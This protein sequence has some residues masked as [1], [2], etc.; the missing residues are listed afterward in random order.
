MGL[1]LRAERMKKLVR[2]DFSYSDK[3]YSE[4]PKTMDQFMDTGFLL[5]EVEGHEVYIE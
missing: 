5:D 2:K 1:L 4:H 3:Q